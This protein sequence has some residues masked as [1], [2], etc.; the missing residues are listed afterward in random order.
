MKALRA[1]RQ[2]GFTL[3]EAIVALV[4]FSMGAVALYGWLGVSLEGLHAT[5]RAQDRAA[6]TLSGLEA[7]RR[8]NPMEEASGRVELEEFTYQWQSRVLDGPRDAVGRLGAPTIF[9]VA[10]YEMDVLVRL[11]D[12][13][14][15]DFTVRQIGYR[16]ARDLG[17]D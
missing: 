15:A 10:L 17:E 2:A 8:V 3:L 12:E 14:V 7:M 11:G 13:D 5:T 6:A 16:Q 1:R 4:V 9:E